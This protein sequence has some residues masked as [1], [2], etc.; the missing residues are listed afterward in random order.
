MTTNATPV[1]YNRSNPCTFRLRE[2]RM[3]VKEGSEKDTRH[4]EFDLSGTGLTFEPGDS[5]ALFSSNCPDLVAD[6][7]KALDFSGNE[8][9]IGPNKEPTTIGEALLNQCAI[10]APD[11]KLL[12][13]ICAKVGDEPAAV[14][15]SALLAP[16]M[17]Q[18]LADHLWGR[19][20]ID[21]L[22]QF[23]QAKFEP[24]EF[25]SLLRKLTVRL[26]SIASSLAHSP[27]QVD[28]TVAAVRYHSFGRERK[29]VCSTWLAD[30]LD[31]DTD[32]RG[33]ISPGK[34][35]RLPDPDDE[36]PIIMIGPG[37]GIAPFRA[38]LQHREATHAKG[39]TW[40]FF[41]ETHEATEFFYRE[42]FEAAM[43]SGVLDRLTTAFSRDQDYKI[44]VQHRLKERGA[45]VW[46]WLE[47]GAIVY[48]CGDANRM[49]GDVDQ[50]LHEI[51]AE[52]GDRSEEAAAEYMENLRTAKRYRRDV[53]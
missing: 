12:A 17:K 50:A 26:Y 52:H 7:L 1:V 36:V 49:A 14:E 39:K 38:F 37:T 27:D 11:K 41:G 2:R 30:R 32:V 43:A 13:A 31:T 28:L 45:D 25:V 15:L 6:I 53:Y 29:G 47:E 10:T 48:V 4:Y 9:V 35:F 5:L 24:Q 40:L 44:Y 8:E 3:L 19:E 33:F 21:F 18:A 46:Q 42:E 34:G 23:P 16:E 20:I 51:V 22:L